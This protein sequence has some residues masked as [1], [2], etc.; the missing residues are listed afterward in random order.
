M[1]KASKKEI[2][3]SNF[4]GRKNRVNVRIEVIAVTFGTIL[5][6]KKPTAIK[7]FCEER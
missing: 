5:D 1:K 7:V 6:R 3:A 2:E 4:Y